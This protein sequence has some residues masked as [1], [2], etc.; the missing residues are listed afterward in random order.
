[1]CTSLGYQDSAGKAYFGRTLE[2]TMDLPLE[3]TFFPTGYETVSE[4][5]GQPALTLTS[6]H[7]IAVTMPYRPPTPQAPLGFSDLKILEGP[8]DK[9]L[10]FSLLSYPAAGGTQKSADVTR[11]VLSASDLGAWA[12]GQFE[13]VAE[14]K[15]AFTVQPVMLQPLGLLGGAESPFHY[16]VHDAT[17]LLHRQMGSA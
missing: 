7:A 13:T 9:G 14:V 17:G 8:N 12:V 15:T 10:T 2:L 3:V 5:E 6:R 11:S 1:M 4:V 16:V